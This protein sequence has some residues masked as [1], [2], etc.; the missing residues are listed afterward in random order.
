MQFQC[1]STTNIIKKKKKKKKK[2]K[3]EIYTLVS[4]IKKK[5]HFEIYTLVS[6]IKYHVPVLIFKTSRTVNRR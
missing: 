3:I 5:K 4:N 6:Y 2:K 1:I